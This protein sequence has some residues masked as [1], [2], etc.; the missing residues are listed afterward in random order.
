MSKIS[1]VLN[2]YT[3]RPHRYIKKGKVMIVDTDDG[4][5]V[6]KEKTRNNKADIYGY[7]ESRNFH[8]YPKTVSDKNDDYEIMEYIEESPMPRD[9]KMADLIDLLGLL[10]AK[11][12]H[13]K[14]V[15]EADYKEIY[16]DIRNNIEYLYSY[17]NDMIAVIE[18]KIFMSPS[19]YLLA[20]NISKV[21]SALN[22]C[23][24]E[25]EHWYELIKTKK[26]QRLVVLHNQLELNHFLKNKDAY[27]I[28]W[29]KAKV[30]LPIFDFYKLYKKHNLEFEFESLL[31][32]YE[33][34][35]PLLE[36]ERKLLFIL[37][38]LPLKMS[39]EGSEYEK[40]KEIG[41]EIDTLYK[42]E[43]LISPYY[44]KNTEYSP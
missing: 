4:R 36:E 21:Y 13:Y 3:L 7:L 9:Q 12:T 32:L 43:Q 24:T 18:T 23:K 40:C 17:Y 42:T 10:H 14:E 15:D 34:H 16:E 2:K 41:M 29:D 26:K 30:G 35:Y 25:L 1:D 37:I 5:F 38:A 20:R 8:Y 39:L 31:K 6:L 28:N 19:E 33:N 44:A 22:Y 11:T 27:F